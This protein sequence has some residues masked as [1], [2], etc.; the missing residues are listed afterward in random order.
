MSNHFEMKTNEQAKKGERYGLYL[1]KI[2]IFFY[3][4]FYK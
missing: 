3:F 2:Y 1:L 4:Q